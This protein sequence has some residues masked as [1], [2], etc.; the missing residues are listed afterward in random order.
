MIIRR[1]IGRFGSLDAGYWIKPIRDA[2]VQLVLVSEGVVNWNDFTGRVM[3]GLKQEGKN[4][5]LRDLSRNMARGLIFNA[6]R[7]K[8]GPLC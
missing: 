2:G 1:S 6:Q 3:Y 5:Y 8:V 4:Q 7:G